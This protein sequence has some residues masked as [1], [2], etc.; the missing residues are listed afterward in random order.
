MVLDQLQSSIVTIDLSEYPSGLYLI[1]YQ[2]EN[3]HE[4]IKMSK[5]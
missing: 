1:K 5:L 2:D 4:V 3:T